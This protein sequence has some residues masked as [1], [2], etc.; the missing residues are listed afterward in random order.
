ME[1]NYEILIRKLD[2]FIRKYY[3]NLLI[4][5]LL[6][7]S[8][9]LV[10]FFIALN[11]LEYFAWFNPLARTLLFILFISVIAGITGYFIINPA[12]KLY[13]IGS[14]I[15]HK[16]AAE[17][18][19]KHFAEVKDKLLNTLQLKEIASQNREN[20]EL[21]EASIDQKI[22]QIKPVNFAKAI[23]IKQNKKYLK[24][25]LPPLF[26]LCAILLSAPGLVTEPV[27]RI[28]HFSKAYKKKL[29]YDFIIENK[30]L[31]A[32]QQEDFILN[33][34]I[35]GN[36][37]PDKLTVEYDNSI[38]EM[39]KD[40]EI[41]YSYIFKNLQ[42]NVKFRIKTDLLAS[43]TYEI[44]V[45]PKPIIL[46]FDVILTY[47]AYT[48]KTDEVLQNIGDQVVPEGTNIAWKFFT[49]D[50]KQLFLTFEEKKYT[51]D[52]HS[53]NYFYYQ[54]SFYKNEA[55]S[56]M[57]SNIYMINRD[58]LLF[59]ISVIKDAFPSIEL[60][61][62]EDSILPGRKFFTGSIKDDY[63]FKKLK[64][65]VSKKA[66]NTRDTIL[67][68]AELNIN[69]KQNQQS[70]YHYFDFS[71]INLLPGEQAEYYFEIWDNDAVNGSKSARTIV[72]AFK[73]PT[74]DEIKKEEEKSD[75]SLKEQ[76]D[77]AIN[78][79]NKLMKQADDLQKKLVDKKNVSWQEKKQ[80]EDI[81]KRQ[82]ELEDKIG[83]IQKKYNENTLKKQEFNKE[84]ED[85][86]DK[87]K[88]LEKLFQDVLTDEMKKQF[89]E[90]Q[91]LMDD[92]NKDKMKDVLDKIKLNNEDIKKE[93]DRN[94]ELFKQLEVEKRMKDAIDKLSEIKDQQQ[95][96]SEQN[97]QNKEELSKM[98]N[99]QDSLNKKFNSLTQD[100]QKMKDQN[101]KLENP[102]PIPDTK[103]EENNIGEKMQNASEQMKNNNQKKGKQNQKDAK[104]KMD[105]LLKK[106][107]QAKEKMEEE[108][109][110]E[111]EQSLRGILE[112]LLKASFE[113]EDLMTSL[114]TANYKDPRLNRI[115]QDQKNL[116][117]DLQIVEDSLFALSKRQ[118]MI[119]AI[120]NRE[121]NK[122]NQKADQVLESLKDMRKQQ[123]VKD[124]QYIMQ[125][126]NELALILA[127]SLQEMQNKQ[128]QNS[129]QSC[130]KKGGK[131]KKPGNSKPSMK[132]MKQM[133]EDLN[134]QME[135]LK[136]QVQE[137]KQKGQYP[138][139]M[140][141]QLAKLAA[142][143][144][145]IRK[146]MQEYSDKLKEETG[147]TDN[148]LNKMMQ[149]MQKTQE[150]IVNK[151]LNPET[152]KRQ[153]EIL[154]RM[155]ESE[156]AEKERGKEEKRESTEGKDIN[157]GNKN[158]FLEYNRLKK[159]E[160]EILKTVPP[161]LN[162]FYKQKLEE[163][164]L[165]IE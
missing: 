107:E 159:K 105:D 152:I 120:V 148:N 60:K 87:Q 53:K 113:Q 82:K 44:K 76:M 163:Y 126:I 75:N 31:Q 63:G 67:V 65:I 21:I 50:T 157:N 80:L 138:K 47:P 86:I 131:C 92:L 54:R 140:S 124:Q 18:I 59:N 88:E 118:P 66:A 49:R 128:Q 94:L 39:R 97:I 115:I 20:Q 141:E 37:I 30:N 69:P 42:K 143:Q 112:N 51:L 117:D 8:G 114:N 85:I 11:I 55:Y 104:E 98:I 106:M 142:Q 139:N 133:Q 29:P 70:F 46:N 136:K 95:K 153:E 36:E 22:T 162:T 165:K 102:N 125:S 5:G 16:H 62:Y 14:I 156:K 164:Y 100:M 25:A 32:I 84:N 3:K 83:E 74:R 35:T 64:F 19:G 137:G 160:D 43:E 146:M 58:S 154:T 158:Q 7:S 151:N 73:L 119:K 89:L 90:L 40:G 129:S 122:I 72:S 13:K 96:L 57:P 149:D 78:D 134:K 123:A 130:N 121:I 99:K 150:E 45:L 116:R 127:E 34:G 28:L 27:T 10:S 108:S 24:Y 132:T 9:M 68:S 56:L 26:I 33:V 1:S 93:L 15:T 48:G 81:L 12:L 61:T 6:L 71:T 101:N 38:Y 103:E 109:L 52:D 77:D 91:Q 147:K 135:A 4:K 161:S 145:A 110:E 2:F 23:N 155:L 111:D 17:I 144:E 79:L 41:K